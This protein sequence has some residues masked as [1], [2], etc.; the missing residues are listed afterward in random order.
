MTPEQREEFYDA[1]VSPVLSDL[2]NRCK[3]AGMGFVA[4][5]DWSGQ[6]NIGRTAALPV[7]APAL[8]RHA[9]ALAS[10]D[11][12]NDR[13]NF[14]RFMFAIMREARERGHSSVILHQLGIPHEPSAA[15]SVASPD[16]NPAVG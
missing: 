16:N 9:N 4:M 11:L 13:I 14:D 10:A 3:A 12:S 7:N 5:V 1:E 8:L 15:E 2:A 6:G